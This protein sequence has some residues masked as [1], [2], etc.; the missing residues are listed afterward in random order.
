MVIIMELILSP[1]QMKMVENV[2]GP[3]PVRDANGNILGHFERTLSPE[4]IA[5]LKRRARAP[6]PRFSGQQVQ[7]R[8]QALQEEWDRT[9]GFDE[10]YMKEFLARLN[11]ADPGHMRSREPGE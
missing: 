3:V 11:S 10:V 4:M 1:E 5:E 2:W 7:A 6:G 8:L 9:G